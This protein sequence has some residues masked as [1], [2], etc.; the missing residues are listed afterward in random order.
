MTVVRTLKCPFWNQI[1]ETIAISL[2]STSTRVSAHSRQ[3]LAYGFPD[4][5]FTKLCVSVKERQKD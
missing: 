4:D 3:A 5:G 2:A 1:A